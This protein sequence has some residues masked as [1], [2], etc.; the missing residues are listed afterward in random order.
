MSSIAPSPAAFMRARARSRRYLRS[1]SQLMRCC[2]SSPTMPAFA[3]AFFS[4]IGLPVQ[5][6][7]SIHRRAGLLRD[8]DPARGLGS[9]EVCESLGRA[10]RH[11]F[12]AAL[13]QP[14]DDLGRL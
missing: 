9:D 4:S 10:A 5:T 11:R 8:L 12:G 3:I 6:T 1:R 2:Q 13:G 7:V 14:L